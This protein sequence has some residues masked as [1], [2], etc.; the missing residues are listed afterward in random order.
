MN[1]T[2]K[3]RL[4]VFALV[5]LLIA[6]TGFWFASRNQPK[7]TPADHSAASPAEAVSADSITTPGLQRRIDSATVTD[8]P[9]LMNS[10][11]L[12]TNADE[13]THLISNLMQRWLVDDLSSFAAFLD[14]A[15]LNGLELWELIAPGMAEALRE[16]NESVPDPDYL[17]Q[18][19][20]RVL[21]RAA[22]TDPKSAL[23]WAREFLSDETLDSTLAG[24]AP[25]LAALDPEAAIALLDE[26]QAF[27]NQTRAAAGI[28]LALGRSDYPLAMTWAESFFSE[29]ER[30]FALS[31]VLHGMAGRDLDRA[32]AE[33][34]RVVETMKT[35]YR[36]QVLADRAASGSTVDE[37]YEGLSP[38][39]IEKAEL[40][41]PNANLIYLQNATRAIALALVREDLSQALEWARSM[42]IYQG[43][44]VAMET[45]YEEWSAVDPQAAY[46]TL[47]G[48]PDRR[49]EVVGKLFGAWALSDAESAAASALAMKPGFERDFAI[50]GVARGW[51]DAGGQPGQIAAWADRLQLASEVDRVSAIVA[52]EA[53]YD[54][55][56]LALRQVQRISNPLKRSELFQEVFPNLVEENPNLARTALATV[57]LSPV[58]IEY[59]QEML[60]P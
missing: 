55:P 1:S 18:I 20:E 59:F 8:F 3:S 21:L 31:G 25:E 26:V 40:A 32:A 36:E 17:A 52:S 39:A 38:E 11:L 15:E 54:N 9:G 24:I 34:T 13:R 10:I 30:A 19:V 5:V 37:E 22:E 14:E 58:E 47:M 53:A 60:G 51:V 2:L 33:Y 44:A 46:Q 42:D 50:E 43:R 23:I 6:L 48:E 35:R 28:G 41:R 16:V 29:T 12:V 7:H 49:P 56:A 27:S 57:K 45:I 4:P